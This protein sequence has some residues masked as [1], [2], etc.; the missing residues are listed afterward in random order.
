MRPGTAA[1]LVALI[2]SSVGLS[3]ESPARIRTFRIHGVVHEYDG[4]AVPGTRVRFEGDQVGKSVFTDGSGFYEADLPLGLYKVTAD[5]FK[6]LDLRFF[7]PPPSLTSDPYRRDLQGYE[8]PLFRVTSPGIITLDITLDPAVFCERGAIVTAPSDGELECGGEDSFKIPSNDGVP[9]E[10]LIRFRSRRTNEHGY[11]YNTRYAVP[12]LPVFVA[13][14]S[15]TLRADQVVYD[16]QARALQATGHVVT[17]NF[18]GTA[19]RAESITLKIDNGEATP[20]P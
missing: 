13:Y 17:A 8:R 12:N 14:N 19:Q 3:A 18:D 20:L 1:V 2:L 16:V 10:L 4:S 9:F 5:A 15:F 7:P 11:A 6:P